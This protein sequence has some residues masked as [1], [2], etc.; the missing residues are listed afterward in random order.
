VGTT[1]LTNFDGFYDGL[2]SNPVPLR[3]SAWSPD[4]KSLMWISGSP[5]DLRAMA[6]DIASGERRELLDA[7]RMRDAIKA[8]TGATPAGRGLPFDNF[9]YLSASVGLVEVGAMTMV[10]GLETQEVALYPVREGAGPTT[11]QRVGPHGDL[12]DAVEVASPSGDLYLSTQ[13]FNI[14]MRA[15]GDIRKAALTKDGTTECDWRFDS[16]QPVSTWMGPTLSAANWSPD[17]TRIAVHRVDHS[18]VERRAQVHYVTGQHD[19]VVFRYHTKAGGVLPC[20]TLYVLDLFGQ[21]PVEIDIPRHCG[22]YLV[23]AGWLAGGK[24]L[25]EFKMS[26]DCR[27]VEVFLADATS[28]QTS[29]IF[30]EEGRTFIRL[31][32]YVYHGRQLG[33]WLVP[34]GQHLI[35]ASERSGFRQLY[36]YDLSGIEVRQLT[37]EPWPA[38]DVV[39]ICDEFVQFLGHGD[40]D[41]PYDVHLY[42]VPLR[43]GPVEVLTQGSGIHRVSFS[44]FSNAFIDTFSKPDQPPAAV[45]RRSDGSVVAQLCSGDLGAL[46]DLGW[47][48]PRE[49]AV[50]AA[51]GQTLL[52]GTMFFPAGFDPAARYPLIEMIYAGPQLAVAPHEFWTPYSRD[53]QALAQLG[54]VVAI[55]DARGTPERSKVFHDFVYRNW[56]GFVDDH[57]AAIAE[58]IDR[59][60][61][62]DGDRVGVIGHSWGGYAAFRCLAERPDIYRAAVASAPGFDPYGSVLYECYLGLPQDDIGAYEA[63]RVVDLVGELRRPLLLACGTADHVTWTDAVKMSEALIR[64]GK[65]HE[66]VVLPEQ[67]H[68]FQGEHDGYFWRKVARFFSSTLAN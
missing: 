10:V 55:V 5:D 16:C 9:R 51:D 68:N 12:L 36:L 50:P 18:G 62:L 30:S 20:T 26:R 28:G 7:S 27:R 39:H 42:R 24:E 8:I 1:G 15:A 31:Q 61:W 60:P 6:V 67:H 34:D 11:F 17:G 63:A 32:D 65:D 2:A 49:F 14:V 48:A 4:E 56:A 47:I 44:P 21:P 13:D 57:A 53:A 22:S 52:W 38:G 54:Y 3:S 23:H 29:P 45:A 46:E 25:I 64:A 37:R 35:W 59:E 19:D 41:R 43:G 40:C 66:F 58:L 33:L